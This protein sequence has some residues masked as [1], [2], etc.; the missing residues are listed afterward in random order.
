MALGRAS[1][2]EADTV[3]EQQRRPVLGEDTMSAGSWLCT[4]LVFKSSVTK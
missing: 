3:G 2:R 4:R 1:G